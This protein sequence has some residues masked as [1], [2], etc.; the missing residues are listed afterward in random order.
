[1]GGDL[2]AAEGS[3][4]VAAGAAQLNWAAAVGHAGA[5]GVLGQ[6]GGLEV[7]HT[8]CAHRFDRERACGLEANATRCR[9]RDRT[10]GRNADRGIQ[11]KGDT[12][13]R[14]RIGDQGSRCSLASLGEG[15]WMVGG[16]LSRVLG[17]DGEGIPAAGV[18]VVLLEQLTADTS[19]VVLV[20]AVEGR[21]AHLH[22]IAA[23][24]VS[25]GV[26]H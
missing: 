7:E 2:E 19:A 22:N 26:H 21:G 4:D 1:M 18:A 16:G 13:E 12:R 14:E 3:T 6:G 20:V 24:Q 25:P 8:G 17:A 5:R 9:R 15:E 11:P 23:N 10:A